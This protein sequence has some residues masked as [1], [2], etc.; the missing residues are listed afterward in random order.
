MPSWYDNHPRFWST[1]T[2]CAHGLDCIYCCWPCHKQ[3]DRDGYC[4][5][6]PNRQKHIRV[7][8][9]AWEL[10]HNRNMPRELHA[11]HWCHNPPCSNP[12]HIYAG[13]QKTNQHHSHK[14]GRYPVGSSHYR[15]KLTEQEI[16]EIRRL[17][18]ENPKRGQQSALGRQYNVSQGVIWGI[19]MH[20]WWKHVP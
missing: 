11:L 20:K 5:W 3:Q 4:D 1:V 19:I 8:R 2:I 17:W 6:H 10:L 13:T 12:H 18:A 14:D 15:A 16:T 9:H 7:H